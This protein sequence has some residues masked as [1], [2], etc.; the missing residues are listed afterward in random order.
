MDRLTKCKVNMVLKG[1]PPVLYLLFIVSL[2]C[3]VMLYS[4]NYICYKY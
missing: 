2:S 4:I 1:V 3:E